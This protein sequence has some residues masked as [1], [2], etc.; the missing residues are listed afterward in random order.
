[1]LTQK[2]GVDLL[3]VRGTTVVKYALGLMDALYTE[4][5]LSTCSFVPVGKSTTS[6]K[7]PLSP[8]RMTLLEGICYRS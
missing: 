6:A 8:T 3:K 1:M 7:P 4:E 5:E 2:S